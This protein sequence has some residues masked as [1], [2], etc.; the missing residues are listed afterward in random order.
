MESAIGLESTYL[1]TAMISTVDPENGTGATGENE[2]TAQSDKAEASPLVTAIVGDD[3]EAARSRIREILEEMG[4]RVV[5]EFSNGELL[6][7]AVLRLRPQLVTVDIRMPGMN[8]LVATERIK[9]D[10][11]QTRVFV[12]TNYPNE[13][14]RRAA[15]RAGAD[16]F[17]AKSDAYAGL[18]QAI[19]Q[20]FG[21]RS[22][23]S[24]DSDQAQ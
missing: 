3:H 4:V 2:P 20:W 14:Y 18:Q 19:K 23:A 10:C 6:L 16:A 17:L 9:H 13:H 15:E 11:P 12:V 8:G 5:A 7:D 21:L 24:E 1:L 22:D